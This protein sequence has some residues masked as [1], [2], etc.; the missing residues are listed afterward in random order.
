MRKTFRNT[1]HSFSEHEHTP[2][3]AKHF[4]KH[5]PYSLSLYAHL[6][7]GLP[8]ISR[9]R[10]SAEDDRYE[11]T[12]LRQTLAR[13]NTSQIDNSRSSNSDFRHKPPPHPFP[14]TPSPTSPGSSKWCCCSC[15]CFIRIMDFGGGFWRHVR[16]ENA[17]LSQRDCFY[18]WSTVLLLTHTLEVFLINRCFVDQEIRTI[19]ILYS[20]LGE[21]DNT[22]S[23]SF[24]TRTIYS[25]ESH[26]TFSQL[27][28]TFWRL[29]RTGANAGCFMRHI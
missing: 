23:H 17:P 16:L 15:V 9:A 27:R 28:T 1:P 7:V 10:V 5:K 12:E 13:P 29:I 3:K 11:K 26:S 2:L 24:N 8:H 20:H 14:P 4:C 25:R 21:S 18:Y 22:F 6:S 19:K